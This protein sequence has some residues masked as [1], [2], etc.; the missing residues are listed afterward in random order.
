MASFQE[1]PQ[2]TSRSEDTP[3][4]LV[5]R[6][7]YALGS[8]LS[9]GLVIGLGVWGYK[10]LVRDVSGVPV[11]R[12]AEGPMRVQPE[13]PGGRQTQNQGL[14]VNDVAAVGAAGTAPDQLILAPAP[15][16]LSDEDA[17]GITDAPE[18]A[19]E[20][21]VQ[22]A[23][24][25]PELPET[26]EMEIAE[27]EARSE[28]QTDT[29]AEPD[30]LALAESI[31]QGITPM[32]DLPDPSDADAAEPE[33]EGAVAASMRPRAR[34]SGLSNIREVAAAA[35]AAPGGRDVD[36]E[37]IPVGTR[38]AQLGAFSSEEIAREEW[39][40]L[41]ARFEEYLAG[42]DRVIQRATSGG[43]TFYRLRAMGFDDLAEARRFC[44]ALVSEKA[45]CIPVVTR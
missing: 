2:Q 35:P 22:T 15:L 25:A 39:N 26:P 27:A 1:D 32:E 43:R 4:H 16:D 28:A 17:A 36:P 5:T 7:T 23:Q 19:P 12:A 14:S 40:R 42:K 3:V 8:I 29:Q 41:D 31:S 34:P 21:D 6:A 10:L 30:M 33:D 20:S 37:T 11:I 44:S 38:L 24:A 18:P 9:V 13:D 45:E